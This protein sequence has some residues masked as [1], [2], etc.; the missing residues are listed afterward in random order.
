M[1]RLRGAQEA[2]EAAGRLPLR[3]HELAAQD[4]AELLYL[5]GIGGLFVTAAAATAFVAMVSGTA[6]RT[7]IWIW[8]AALL[9]IVA[10]RAIDVL[11]GRRRR[12]REGW[13]R[14]RGDPA[15]RLRRRRDGDCVDRD[16]GVVLSRIQSGRTNDARDHRVGDGGWRSNRLGGFALARD[17]LLRG[18]VAPVVDHVLAHPEPREH[19][20]GL[21]R[22]HFL[23]RHLGGLD[24]H[25]PRDDV[26][27]SPQPGQ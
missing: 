21:P 11:A 2:V 3:E 4:A 24:D 1:R 7:G 14:A 5:H 26:G 12:T 17:R 15:V 22:H 16:A 10:L 13:G 25:A 9:L 18:P 20:S 19:V 23:R 6:P 8:L 27:D